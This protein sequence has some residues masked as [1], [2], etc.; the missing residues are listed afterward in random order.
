[1]VRQTAIAVAAVALT[2]CGHASDTVRDWGFGGNLGTTGVGAEIKTAADKRLMLRGQINVAS[3]DAGL[4]LDDIDYDGRVD[5]DTVAAF[6]DIAP[7]ENGFVISGGAY[8]GQ[9]AL[10]LEATPTANVE[11]G[12]TSFTPEQVGTLT[13]RTEFRRVAPYI[14]IGYDTF[15]RGRS[16]WSFNARAGVMFAGSGDVSLVS[17]NG[18]LSNNPILQDELRNEIRQ[19]EE[20]IEQYKYYPVIS[21][22]VTRRF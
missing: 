9:K 20:D 8:V 7:F 14:G 4:E 16:D 10:D 11:I 21:V 19:I 18:T 17:A 2:A 6:A 12:G 1:M 15:L 3:F 13:T 22:G 5:A